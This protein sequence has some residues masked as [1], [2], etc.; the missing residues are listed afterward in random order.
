[1][2][3]PGTTHSAKPTLAV[4][5]SQQ[6]PGDAERSSIMS[7]AGT[8]FAR[9]GARIVCLIDALT[10]PVPLI[11]SARAAGGEVV[12]IADE[13]A[14]LLP[15][16]QGVAVERIAEVGERL[17]RVST[18]ADGFIGLPGSLA[19]ASSLYSAWVKGGGGQGGKPVVLYNRNHAF[20][21]LRGYVADVVSHSRRGH[22]QVVQFAD[23]IEDSWNRIARMLNLH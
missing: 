11:T 2:Q 6:G 22:E 5:A 8:Y 20:E 10:I 21:V 23:S 16:L 19:S 9:K 14:P 15:A 1:M 7:Q 12:I 18:L 17:T 13:R 3:L 4:F